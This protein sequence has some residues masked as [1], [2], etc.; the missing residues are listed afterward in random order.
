MY[1]L[2]IKSYRALPLQ[3]TITVLKSATEEKLIW[4]PSY[5]VFPSV[6]RIAARLYECRI[7][8]HN[9][10]SVHFLRQ[11]DTAI[12]VLRSVI[13][14]GSYRKQRNS[15]TYLKNGKPSR[16]RHRDCTQAVNWGGI[17]HRYLSD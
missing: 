6:E 16:A 9:I 7:G 13:K 12:S 2:T 17:K 1:N 8:M 14:N 10:A 4:Q 11:P 3:D 5:M 15:S